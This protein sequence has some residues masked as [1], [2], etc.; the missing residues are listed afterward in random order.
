MPSP[1]SDPVRPNVLDA[2]PS[3]VILR[4]LGL[5]DFLTGLPAYRAV[6]RAFPNHHKVLAAPVVFQPLAR[7]CGGIDE[8]VDTLPLLPVHPRLRHADV[9]IDLHG[10]GPESHRILLAAQ[11]RRLIAFENALIAESTGQAQWNQDEHEVARWCR[12]LIHNGIHAD[13]E[14]LDLQLPTVP[15][16]KPGKGA[17]LLHPGAASES[18]RWPIERW[19]EIARAEQRRGHRVVI[20]GSHHEIARARRI[21]QRAAIPQKNVYAGRTTLAQLASLVA[22]AA[23][24]VCGDTGI[25]HLATAFRIPSVVL[26]GPTNPKHWGPPQSRSYHQVLWHGEIG[27]PHA[28]SVDCG[29][30]NITVE[31]VLAGLD[32]LSSAGAQHQAS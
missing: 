7:L 3:V 6:A 21:A 20:T 8:L 31:Q 27:D 24:V 25:A 29:L 15:V 12:L 9:A 22:N 18:R 16:S 11:P 1:I 32:R 2:R 10:K 30:A 19:I 28:E 17:T 13:C 14:D 4:P 5:G 23:R 26:F